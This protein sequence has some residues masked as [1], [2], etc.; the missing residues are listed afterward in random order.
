MDSADQYTGTCYGQN[1]RDSLAQRGQKTVIGNDHQPKVIEQFGDSRELAKVIRR[2]DWNE[3]HIIARENHIIEKIN[4]QLMCELIDDDAMARRDGVIALQIHAGQPMK[5]QFRNLRLKELQPAATAAPAQFNRLT[6]AETAAG[7]KP[8]FDGKTL[9]GWRGDGAAIWTVLDGAICGGGEGTG[10]LLSQEEFGDFELQADAKI[11]SAG[12]SGVFF[13]ITPDAMSP[14]KNYEIQVIGSEMRYPGGYPH[15][16]DLFGFAKVSENY[17]QDDRWF[18]LHLIAVGNQIVV[19]IDG[20]TVL[21]YVDARNSFTRGSIGLQKLGPLTRVSYRNIRVKELDGNRLIGT[22][23]KI[24]ATSQR[25]IDLLKLVDPAKDAISGRWRFFDNGSLACEPS[26]AAQIEIPYDPPEEYDYRIVFVSDRGNDGVEQICRG[27]GR[28]FRF[29]VGG[30]GNTVAGFD[31]VKGRLANSNPTT[32]KADHWLVAGQRHV[33]VV[34]VRKDGVEGWFD[35]KR[36]IGHKTDWTDMSLPSNSKLRRPDSIG[37]VAWPGVR[38][39]S[40]KIIEITGE[41]RYLRSPPAPESVSYSFPDRDAAM[42]EFD[43]VG[44]W[45]VASGNLVL[46]GQAKPRAKAVSKRGFVFPLSVEWEVYCLPDRPYDL[47]VGFAGIR[48]LFADRANTRTVLRLGNENRILRHHPAVPGQVYRIVLSVYQD[49]TLVIQQDGVEVFNGR[50]DGRV[51]LAGPVF[52]GDLAG[53]V[54]CK[55]IVVSGLTSPTPPVRTSDSLG[56]PEA[57]AYDREVATWA[58]GVNGGVAV[59]LATGEHK[60]VKSLP[61]EPFRVIGLKLRKCKVNDNDAASLHGLERL[62]SIDLSSTNTTDETLKVLSELPNLE[63]VTL[64]SRRYTPEGL[65]YLG[66]LKK[67][68]HLDLLDTRLTDATLASF[69]DLEDAEL[70]QFCGTLVKGPGLVHLAKMNKVHW[71]S[72]TATP[73]DDA[74]LAFLPDMHGL[75]ILHLGKTKITDAGLDTLSRFPQLVALYLGKSQISGTGLAHLAVMKNLRRLEL[76]GTKLDDEGIANLPAFS[77]LQWLNVGSTEIGDAGL[78]RLRYLPTL[79]E[80]IVQKTKITAQG[81]LKL[82]R[83]LPHCKII[84]DE[85]VMK[86]CNDLVKKK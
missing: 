8:L 62:L 70:L 13:R 60:W 26:R 77:E 71:L 55:K 33:S 79:R 10:N 57:I 54:G 28:Q 6:D 80:L 38:V 18:H 27:G 14:A 30:W 12:N 63:V 16:G 47:F 25:E 66:N 75:R 76:A 24:S 85:A 56:T 2:Q 4:G 20:Q 9:E 67:L 34:K 81:I 61:D 69:S 42:K 29:S 35:D 64:F 45:E 5:V 19:K 43:F 15:T 50:V 22:E 23:P 40:A 31:M 74:G 11:N 51:P 72:L 1:F 73:I 7:W 65:K 86:E 17:I 53:H 3:Y 37:I 83:A 58:L 48:Y 78:E 39:E 84:A 49:R 21:D 36:V 46:N 68:K 82:G 32:T 41:G 52:L 59:E 44:D